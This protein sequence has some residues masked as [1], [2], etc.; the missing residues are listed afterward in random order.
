MERVR[1]ER[2]VLSVIRLSREEVE[3]LLEACE[4]H[5]SNDVKALAIPGEGACLNGARVE[6]FDNPD[7]NVVDIRVTTRQ[8]DILAKATETLKNQPT[9]NVGHALHAKIRQL[10]QEAN[11]E[12]VR[13]NPDLV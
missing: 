13:L 9:V 3:V 1:F 5:Y 4:R 8:I 2:T 10:F 12:W 7:V 6:L 11:Q